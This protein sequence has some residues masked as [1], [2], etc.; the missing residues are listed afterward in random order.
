[1]N[2]FDARIIKGGALLDDTRRFLE[3]WDCQRCP[4]DNLEHIRHGG[5][6]GKRSH[7]RAAAVLAVLR[8]RFVEAGPEVIPTLRLLPGDA[9]AFREACYYEAAC[10][11]PL[12]GA[13]AAEALFASS[14]AG[15]QE[16]TAAEADAWLSENQRTSWAPPTRLRVAQGLLSALRDFGILEGAARKRLAA[17]R[18]S[19]RGF[20]Y[21]AVRE[22]DR[23][24]SARALLQAP[25]WRRF[26]LDDEQVRLLLREADR[27]KL[28]RFA[29]A[30]SAIRI[31]WLIARLEEV[32]HVVA[33]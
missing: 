11:D 32:P 19:M 24:E 30:G 9:R 14:R 21:V 13:F 7:S 23:H 20:A 31:D 2:A 1:M 17:P 27:L 6:L 15:R 28:L 4:A 22:R 33:A 8:R 26:L 18:L 12:L 16:V 25:V 29:E 5:V 10:S 3:A